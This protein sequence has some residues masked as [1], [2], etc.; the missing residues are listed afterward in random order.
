[1]RPFG[2]GWDLTLLYRGRPFGNAQGG[3]RK[4][5]RAPGF[6][7]LP[8]QGNAVQSLFDLLRIGAFE[9][10]FYR[11]LQV[12]DCQFHRLSLARHVELGA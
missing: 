3:E 9:E 10:Q 5:N 6:P 11:F 8:L 4:S 7:V 2:V 1:M 12:G